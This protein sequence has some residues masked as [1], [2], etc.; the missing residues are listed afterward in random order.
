LR[1]V[2]G[3]SKKGIALAN[4]KNAE[5]RDIRVTGYSGPLIGAYGVTGTGLAGAAPIEAPKLPE[6]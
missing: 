5:I 2:T 6:P 1:G 4:I 3:T